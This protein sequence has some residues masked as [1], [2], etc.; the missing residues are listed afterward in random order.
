[1]DLLDRAQRL[2]A[3]AGAVPRD[4]IARAG[5]PGSGGR[6]P[7]IPMRPA[8][9]TAA[10]AVVTGSEWLV[11]AAGCRPE[12]LRSI[13][14]FEALFARIVADLALQ[15]VQPPVWHQF[16]G[17]GGLTG[18]LLLSESHLACHTFPERGFAALN[19]YCC[20]DRPEW[21]WTRELGTTLG[22]EHVTVRRLHRGV[23]PQR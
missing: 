18:L 3:N 21:N 5:R 2:D 10:P 12:A 8:H 17:A 1:M 4:Y 6:I 14:V 23:E 19:L 15:P 9:E 13:P 20:R 7:P 16:P 22:A 11:D